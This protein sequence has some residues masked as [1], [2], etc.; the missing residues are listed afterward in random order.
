[1]VDI[2]RN[3]LGRESDGTSG[4]VFLARRICLLEADWGRQ[5]LT[6]VQKHCR[7]QAL[8]GRLRGMSARMPVPEKDIVTTAV[9]IADE[10]GDNK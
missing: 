7:I 4:R 1:M 10:S 6:S 8:S 5:I 3:S 2:R 9:C